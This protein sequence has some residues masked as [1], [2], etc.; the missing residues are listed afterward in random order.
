VRK[1]LQFLERLGFVERVFG[2]DFRAVV[3][4]VVEKGSFWGSGEVFG[5]GWH[6]FVLL[7][8]IRVQ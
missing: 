1:G 2:A 3:L 7:F 8:F 6:C 5:S 4:E